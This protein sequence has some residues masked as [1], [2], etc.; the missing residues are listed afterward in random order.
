MLTLVE[1]REGFPPLPLD[2]EKLS[3]MIVDVSALHHDEMRSTP[4]YI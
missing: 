2:M 4:W 3:S 1:S